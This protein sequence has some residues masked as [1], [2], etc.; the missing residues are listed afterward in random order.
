MLGAQ[1]LTITPEATRVPRQV[2]AT[3]R[4]G[5]S[6]GSWQERPLRYVVAGNPF[7]SA[8]RKRDWDRETHGWRE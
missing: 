1:N 2:T 7:V 8:S 4:V 5:V 3:A 6:D